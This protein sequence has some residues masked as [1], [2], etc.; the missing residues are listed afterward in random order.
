MNPISF[1]RKPPQECRR[2]FDREDVMLAGSALALARSRSVVISDLSEE[3]AGLNGRDLPPPGEEILFV[4]GT[5]DRMADV[6]WRA[7][8]QCGI[9]FDMPLDTDDVERMKREAHWEKVV[10]C[11]R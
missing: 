5:T 8:D 2:G 3:G 10:G 9:R 6:M 11:W 7:G 1:G 4:A